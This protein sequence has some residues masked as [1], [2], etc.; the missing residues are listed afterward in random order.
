MRSIRSNIHI[1]KVF[2]GLK[3]KK[4]EVCKN[5]LPITFFGRRITK[6]KLAVGCMSAEPCEG[7]GRMG[8]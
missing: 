6:T 8:A 1:K 5:H 2:V 7:R 3:K 4:N